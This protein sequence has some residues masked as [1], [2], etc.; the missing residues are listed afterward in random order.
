MINKSASVVGTIR[1]RESMNVVTFYMGTN[2]NTGETIVWQLFK[3]K[4]QKFTG[5]NI[6]KLYREVAKAVAEKEANWC[7]CNANLLATWG[8]QV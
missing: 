7:N 3:G 8:E 5:K 2:S 6:A 4:S 1:F